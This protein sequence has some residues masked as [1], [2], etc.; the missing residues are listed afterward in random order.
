MKR[1][2]K[3]LTSVH[4]SLAVYTLVFAIMGYGWIRN[5]VIVSESDFKNIDGRMVVRVIGI[6]VVPIGIVMGYLRK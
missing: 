1:Q 3:M 5:V 6:P 4:I 2:S